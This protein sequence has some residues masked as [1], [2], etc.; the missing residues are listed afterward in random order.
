MAAVFDRFFWLEVSTAHRL[1]FISL[2][3]SFQSLLGDFPLL[4]LTV[5][6]HF[7]FFDHLLLVVHLFISGVHLNIRFNL[8]CGH[9]LSIAIADNVVKAED[10]VKSFLVNGSFINLL[11]LA[12][13]DNH[14]LDLSDYLDVFNDV[15]IF[16]CDQ[17]KEELLHG[18]VHI[19]NTLSLDKGALL[20]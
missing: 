1:H 9:T 4:D 11:C 13:T 10:K 7:G 16:G 12:L 14:L 2:I 17:H 3:T 6:F 5:F 20:L 19:S 18:L 8:G 15:R